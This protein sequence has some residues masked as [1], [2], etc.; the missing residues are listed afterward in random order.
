MM[1]VPHWKH[2]PPL[3]ATGIA[4]LLLPFTFELFRFISFYV[5]TSLVL[6]V[7]LHC[8]GPCYIGVGYVPPDCDGILYLRL[9]P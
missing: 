6:Y 1:F 8:F 5:V 9:F 4:L 7:M 2:T 3:P